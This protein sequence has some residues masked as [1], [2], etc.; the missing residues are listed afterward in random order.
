MT[1]GTSTLQSLYGQA[2]KL[3]VTV[4]SSLSR[5]ESS[6]SQVRVVYLFLPWYTNLY[7]REILTVIGLLFLCTEQHS[8]PVLL[9]STDIQ[10]YFTGKG[11]LVWCSRD[12]NWWWWF[13]GS[14]KPKECGGEAVAGIAS[15]M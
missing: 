1:N 5:L 2:R 15:C 6:T 7:I 12:Y 10:Y 14:R 9:L 3:L 8:L 13:G 11:N 4:G